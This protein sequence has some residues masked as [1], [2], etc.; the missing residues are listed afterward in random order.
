MQSRQRYSAL[1]A[2]EPKC[3][4]SVVLLEPHCGQSTASRT[5]S[6]LRGAKATTCTPAAAAQA[7][8]T[9]GNTVCTQFFTP[10]GRHPV[11]SP[12]GCQLRDDACR[13]TR[14]GQ[15]IHHIVCHLAHRR[16]TAVCRG[17]DDL[18]SPRALPHSTQN[19]HLTQV[20]HR[21]FR[22]GHRLQQFPDGM[23]RLCLLA[24]RQRSVGQPAQWH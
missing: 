1:Q 21:D 22:V 14:T 20:D 2:V 4:I 6:P 9:G 5:A 18:Q 13:N 19:T 8:F 23:V 17:D 11:G 24:W 12:G 16:A 3:E 7:L 10:F 15:R